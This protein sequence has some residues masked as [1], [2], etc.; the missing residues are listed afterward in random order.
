MNNSQIISEQVNVLPTTPQQAKKPANMDLIDLVK[1]ILSFVIVAIHTQLFDP[2][3]YPWTRLAVPLFFM[4]SSY[5]FFVKVNACQTAA[6]K[7]KC[8]KGFVLRNLKLYAFWFIAL[9]PVCIFT[10]GWFDYGIINGILNIIINFFVGSTFVASWFISALVIG[11]ALIFFASKKLS[12][13]VLLAIGI[14]YFIL[15]SL[16]SSYLFIFK[17]LTSVLVLVAKYEYYL[18]VPYN[19]IPAGIF[20][21]VCGKIF[22]DGGFRAKVKDSTFNLGLSLALLFIEWILLYRYSGSFN[23]DSYL[24]LAP[25]AITIFNLLLQAKPRKFKYA[26]Q[27]RKIS[28]IIYASHGA[29]LSVVSFIFSKTVGKM[30]SV[31]NFIA[32][33]AI[34]VCGA[35]LV[36]L[37][38]KFKY[39]RWLKYSH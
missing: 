34:C 27:M 2:V 25:C 38:E 37:L 6:E 8:L 23:K 26:S 12:N 24:M 3:L 14:V 28:I 15:V 19:S 4:I 29:V 20:W 31:V 10:R 32:V 36:L 22:A 13:K 11:T 33:S 5:F 21:I 30:P 9:F 39:L 35:L 1:L 18:G 16:R 17:D 7:N